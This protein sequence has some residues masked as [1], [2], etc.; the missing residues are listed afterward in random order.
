MK[1]AKYRLTLHTNMGM[2][3]L[4]CKSV[5]QAI[6]MGQNLQKMGYKVLSGHLLE[7]RLKQLGQ[8]VIK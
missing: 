8:V 4:P 3:V 2:K 5:A 7:V 6:E 1:H